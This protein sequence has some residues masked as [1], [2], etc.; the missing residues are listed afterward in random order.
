MPE[1]ID[2]LRNDPDGIGQVDD[3]HRLAHN[4]TPNNKECARCDVLLA[5]PSPM[6]SSE[7]FAREHPSDAVLRTL[8]PTCRAANLLAALFT[9]S[10]SLCRQVVLHDSRSPA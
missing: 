4:G 7:A 8:E 2:A 6:G 1:G 3:Q 10:T 9:F 5:Q